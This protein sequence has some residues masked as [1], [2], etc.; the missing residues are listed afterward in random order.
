MG[1]YEFPGYPNE[2]PGY[3]P[4]GYNNKKGV[5]Q[6]LKDPYK[7]GPYGPDPYYFVPQYEKKETS[8]KYL[9]DK[10]MWNH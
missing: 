3:Y 10:K 9:D 8:T 1:S 6:S 5:R 7:Y 2:D 4:P